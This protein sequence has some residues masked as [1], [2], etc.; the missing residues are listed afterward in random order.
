MRLSAGVRLGPYRIDAPIASGGMGEVYRATDMRLDR[1][2]AIKL[3]AP[4][5]AADPSFR[6]RFDREAKTISA[7]DHPH[8]CTLYD[9]GHERLESTETGTSDG[10]VDY[11]VM[12]YLEGETLA[13]RLA[14]EA[15]PK[16][17]PARSSQGD[18]SI[19]PPPAASTPSSSGGP[20]RPKTAHGPLPLGQ[21]LRYATEIADALEAAHRHGIVH[22]DL[23]PGNVMLTK[24]GVKLLD[25]GLAKLDAPQTAL[26]GI[27]VAVTRSASL[28]GQG[29]MLGTLQYMSPEQ[30][31]GR[32]VDARS[33]VF[34]FG[35][36]LFEMLT[37]RRAF[38]GASQA[39]VIA[40]IIE[41][42]PPS[43]GD[44]TDLKRALPSAT[45][46]ALN[47]L[48]RKCLAKSPDD[49]WQ[50][51]ADLADELK[52]ID[53]ERLRGAT[54]SESDSTFA[55]V[56]G[57][58]AASRKREKLW[59]GAT[60]ATVLIAVALP[61]WI[62]LRRPPIGEMV[63]FVVSP[64]DKHPLA[65]G[66]NAVSV[67]PDGRRLLFAT[68]GDDGRLW[69]Q[70]LDSLTAEPIQGTEGA[71]QP[72]WSPDG[73]FLGYQTGGGG[74]SQRLKT[75]DLSGGPSRT[76]TDMATGRG[77]WS[78]QGFILFTGRDGRLYRI[79]DVGGQPTPVT[80]L[81]TG[82]QE[83]SHS[84]PIFLPDGRR[85]VF[86][87]KSSEPSKS[88]L[89]LASIES[90][91]RA[92]LI[93][94]ESSVEYSGGYLI[95]QRDG[96]VTAHAF[97]EKNRRLTGEPVPIVDNVA[98]NPV[99][100]R[101]DLSASTRGVLVYRDDSAFLQ[102]ALIWVD[103]T[104][105]EVGRVPG[106]A[107]YRNPRLSADGRRA[108][109]ER[110]E[111][112]SRAD[113]WLIDLERGVPTRF[114]FDRATDSF[115]VW[116]PDGSRVVFCSDRKGVFDLY[117]RAAGGVESEQL[118]FDSPEEK[119][120][121][122]FSP[123]GKVLL[124]DR[125]MG[126][127]QGWDIWAHP[128]TGDG[129]PFPVIATTFN[130]AFPAFSPDGHWIAYDSNDS[131][132]FQVYVEPFPPNGKRVRLSTTTGDSPLWSADGRTVFFTSRR[133]VMAVDVKVSGGDLLPGTPQEL[134]AH[135]RPGTGDQNIAVHPKE[136]RLLVVRPIGNPTS[137]SITVVLNW[138]ASLHKK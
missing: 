101:A 138:T 135:E 120:P 94:V 54:A 132:P 74:G 124:F 105:K 42:D 123:H 19:S 99:T 111:E 26:D 82:R 9:V 15:R 33:D 49:R 70:R 96:L 69:I 86:L 81:D 89:F 38:D 67:S 65:G 125:R 45:Q 83:Q 12:Q 51:T 76:L 64:P 35:A 10:R 30:L 14:R 115:P 13:D 129:K 110:S 112:G 60:A 92:H 73:R 113:L 6:E 39:G 3:I 57:V 34:A 106:Q 100:G 4:H 17:D 29:E 18:G 85:F 55:A 104:G 63:R 44:L 37:G 22:R 68:S 93:D 27:S 130:E 80:H 107:A 87:G 31:E 46:R 108:V 126:P 59:M 137:G 7:L 95:Y 122:S 128:L 75:V 28:T 43:L 119:R 79:P 66:P 118:L 1:T 25:F 56:H 109:V 121:F 5:I 61:S 77:A 40:S 58:T 50:C 16:S 53:E 133:S 98:Y 131:G 48:L 20:T 41:V 21:A 11:L 47:R 114:T 72:F 97:D 88:A 24:S 84:W 2:V 78:S 103:Y 52:W 90:P 23:K 8:I 36:I 62:L 102:R 91:E 32:P 134:F 71:R 116:S 136:Q 127:G 117:Q